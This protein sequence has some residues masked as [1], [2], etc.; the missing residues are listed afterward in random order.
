MFYLII[1]SIIWA[2]SFGLIKTHL[3]GIDSN[4]VAFIRLFLSLLIFLPFYRVRN[5]NK[6]LFFKLILIG[7]VQYGIMYTVYIASYQY[8][9][10]YQV[11]L[12]TIFTPF[13]VTIIND[14]LLK[15]HDHL[16]LKYVLIS[17]L[18]TGI[19][20]Y[21]ATGQI[22]YGFLL[23]QISNITFAFGQVY[24]KQIMNKHKKVKDIEVFSLL[25]LGAVIFTGVVSFFATKSTVISISLTQIL[26]LLYLGIVASGLCFFMWNF[27][28]KHVHAGSLGI[29][30][31][32][33]VPLA[34]L[35]SIIVFKEQTNLVRLTIGGGLIIWAIWKNE[36]RIKK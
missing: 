3:V 22:S 7:A 1:T 8:L 14:L 20:I 11:A 9:A 6:S 31:N 35:A 16:A 29:M 17:I 26:V 27:G 18:G 36:K 28:A 19:I 34:I 13:Y 12:F 4:L 10:A 33:K 25:Y 24:Y 30:N 32:I 23:I 5:L 15:K 21:N 2:F